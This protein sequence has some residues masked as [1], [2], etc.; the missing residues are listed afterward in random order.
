MENLKPDHETETHKWW[1]E[2][3]YDFTIKNLKL[4]N[5]KVFR[6]QHKKEDWREYAIVGS[7]K[8]LASCKQFDGIDYELKILKMIR[9]KQI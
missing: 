1:H 5:V 9:R 8:V 3:T 2:S 6:V 4:N 7:G